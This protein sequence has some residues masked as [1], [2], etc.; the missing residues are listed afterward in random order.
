MKTLICVRILALA[1]V[2]SA[3]LLVPPSV[4]ADKPPDCLACTDEWAMSTEPEWN[5]TCGFA[6]ENEVITAVAIRTVAGLCI[7]EDDDCYSISF[8][9]NEFCAQ[10]IGVPG[11]NCQAIDRIEVCAESIPPEHFVPEPGSLTL[12]LSG[13][14]GMA[15]YA[16]QKFAQI[17]ATS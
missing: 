5:G 11:P 6:W 4:K 9:G 15:A 17:R 13:L 2:F 16:L 1:A 7:Y 14:A 10:R 8:E 12:F 3:L